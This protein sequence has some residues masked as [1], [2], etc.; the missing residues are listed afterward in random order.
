MNTT[1][2]CS[3]VALDSHESAPTW[4]AA[5]RLWIECGHESGFEKSE[6]IWTGLVQAGQ[7]TMSEIYLHAAQDTEDAIARALQGA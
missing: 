3:L 4:A 7:E 2:F 6:P 5:E 1:A